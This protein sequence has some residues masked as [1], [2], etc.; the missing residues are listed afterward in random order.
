GILPQPETS[1]RPS[2]RALRLVPDRQ[3][4]PGPAGARLVLGRPPRRP[5][6]AERGAV[7]PVRE[8]DRAERPPHDGVL[9]PVNPGDHVVDR[10]ERQ[11]HRR[12]PSLSFAFLNSFHLLQPSHLCIFHGSAARNGSRLPPAILYTISTPHGMVSTVSLHLAA[13]FGPFPRRSSSRAAAASAVIRAMCSASCLPLLPPLPPTPPGEDRDVPDD[14][15]GASVTREA[16]ERVTAT[17]IFS[18]AGG[19]GGRPGLFHVVVRPWLAS[20][21]GAL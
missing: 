15:S 11:L 2:P 3:R 7:G 4:R 5:V 12:P 13:G 18:S 17:S 14:A 20:L 8:R 16:S 6:P 19:R 9:R 21:V 10:V 1:S